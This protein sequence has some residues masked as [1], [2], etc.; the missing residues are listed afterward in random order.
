M[1]NTV[2]DVHL[3]SRCCLSLLLRTQELLANHLKQNFC[4]SNSQTKLKESSFLK[5]LGKP[6]SRNYQKCSDEIVLR[7]VK[8]IQVA[9]VWYKLHTVIVPDPPVR[10]KRRGFPPLPGK[11][12]ICSK[13]HLTPATCIYHIILQ[14]LKHLCSTRALSNF[15]SQTC[16]EVFWKGQFKRQCMYTWFPS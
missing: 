12:H 1:W 9:Q 15:P 14:F 10:G 5:V 16:Q 6:Q 11:P 13:L 8:S 4:W 7:R 2:L 3:L